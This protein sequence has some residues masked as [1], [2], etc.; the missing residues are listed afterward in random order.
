[1]LSRI[2][3]LAG[4]TATALVAASAPASAAVVQSCA[5]KG[6]CYTTSP[7]TIAPGTPALGPVGAERSA[8]PGPRLCDT[9]GGGCVDTF[10]LLPGAWVST[11]QRTLVSVTVPSFGVDLASSPATV[12]YGVP[13]VDGNGT[14]GGAVAATVSVPLVPVTSGETECPNAI[15]V[16]EA[17]RYS[18][19]Y[20]T[21]DVEVV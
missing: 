17:V 2:A 6:V 11:S 4:L 3:A 12:Y 8:V 19:C 10:V 9:G 13:T 16:L 21:V 1:M 20:V 14:L 15:H 5:P 7:L 18:N